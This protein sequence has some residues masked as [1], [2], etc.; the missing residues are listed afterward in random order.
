MAGVSESNWE[1]LGKV[2]NNQV[3]RKVFVPRSQ[4]V[5]I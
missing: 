2:N 4:L 3:Y 1:F 5:R